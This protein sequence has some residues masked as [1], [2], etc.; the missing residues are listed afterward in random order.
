MEN[1][2]YDRPYRPGQRVAVETEAVD[3]RAPHPIDLMVARRIRAMREEKGFSQQ[4][5]ATRCGISFQ[6]LQKYE[7]GKNRVST[8]RLHAIAQALGVPISS[9]L[10]GLDSGEDSS[11]HLQLVRRLETA[12]RRVDEDALGHLVALAERLTR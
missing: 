4:A 1:S 10:K 3:A 2:R 7:R 6:Q 11:P 12:A 8:A 9:L 5:L